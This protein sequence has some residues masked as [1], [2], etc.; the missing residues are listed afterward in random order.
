MIRQPVPTHED[1]IST[2][3]NQ[4]LSPLIQVLI[5]L[6]NSLCCLLKYFKVT[7]HCPT[8]VINQERL[9]IEQICRRVS[10]QY[11]LNNNLA[12]KDFAL[13]YTPTSEDGVNKEEQE[14]V[15]NAKR[16]SV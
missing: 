4:W 3:E 14:R 11:D 15:D 6:I 5:Y 12:S 16:R 13:A 8:P 7:S 9:T 1:A 2:K 10:V